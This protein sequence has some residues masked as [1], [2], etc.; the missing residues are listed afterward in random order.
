MNITPDYGYFVNMA[1]VL[2]AKIYLTFWFFFRMLGAFVIRLTF[3]KETIM[4]TPT[5]SQFLEL[6]GPKGV[7]KIAAA[8]EMACKLA[9]I[10]E[11]ICFGQSPTQIAKKFGYT[12]QR[13]FQIFHEFEKSGSATLISQKTGPKQKTVLKANIVKQ[14][15]RHRFLDPEANSAVIAQKLSQTGPHVS[16]R[17]VERVITDFG[18]QK[19][20]LPIPTRRRPP[21]NRNSKNQDENRNDPGDGGLD[22]TGGAAITGQ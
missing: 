8:D 14:I 1:E 10:I 11:V 18:L 17:S 20:N 16:Q 19:K 22:G 13:Y 5:N 6:Q 21:G 9:M 2:F 15:I 3:K 4:N 7:L 12:K